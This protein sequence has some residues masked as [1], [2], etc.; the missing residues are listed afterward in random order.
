MSFPVG[1][2]SPSLRLN[3]FALGAITENSDMSFK[4]THGGIHSAA[5]KHGVV[6]EGWPPHIKLASPS[7]IS[8]LDHLCK[9]V[10]GWRGGAIRFRRGTRE[11]ISAITV[12][13]S[14][15]RVPRCDKGHKRQIR[16]N[17]A[18]RNKRRPPKE[19]KSAMYVP[20]DSDE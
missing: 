5:L 2:Q 20:S 18:L 16:D 1:L 10:R 15:P 17:P 12:D 9:L 13:G 19:I 8:S 11:E 14:L 3:K 6:L 7:A 4:F